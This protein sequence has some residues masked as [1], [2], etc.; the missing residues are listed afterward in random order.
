MK[1]KKTK[2]TTIAEMIAR[3]ESMREKLEDIGLGCVGCPMSQ[4]ETLEQ[5][6]IGHGMDPEELIRELNLDKEDE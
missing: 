3:D 5:G 4:F 6:A 2:K 1:G